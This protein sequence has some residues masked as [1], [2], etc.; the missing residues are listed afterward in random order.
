MI[1]LLVVMLLVSILATAAFTVY[2]ESVRS[3]N[4]RAAHAALLENARFMEQFY[5]KKG[6]FKLTSTK[7]PELPVKEAGGFCIRMS[8]QAKGILEGKFTL[9][10]VALDREAEPR[11]LRL[12]ESLTAV[13]CGKMK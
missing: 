11:V 5:T 4:L 10:A 2:R 7:W 8:G 13:V 6:S 1:Q 3:A 12:N 9:K